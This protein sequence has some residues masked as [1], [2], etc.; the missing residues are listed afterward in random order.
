PTPI[1]GTGGG[2]EGAAYPK[3]DPPATD[4]IARCNRPP[5][6]WGVHSRVPDRVHSAI[7]KIGP[8]A[9]P[10][11]A[12]AVSSPEGSHGTEESRGRRLH[13]EVRRV[14]T[15]DP[16]APA[17]RRAR[18]L[19]A[20]RGGPEVG[21]PALHVQGDPRQHGRLQGALRLRLLERAAP[22]RRA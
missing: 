4:A 1:G 3:V 22:G 5:P 2:D 21:L 9:Q 19:P 17:R 6:A 20:D 10:A 15:T 14:R 16:E 8:P 11:A 12:L 18:R 7:L 13:R